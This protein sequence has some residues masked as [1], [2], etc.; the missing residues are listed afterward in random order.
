MAKGGFKVMDSD[1]HVVE[2]ADLWEHYIDPAFKDRAPQGLSRHPRD[3][4]VRVGD[5]VYPLPNRSYSNAIAPLMTAQMDVYGRVGAP[6]LGQR[7]AAERDGPRGHRRCRAVPQPRPVHPGRQQH[8]SRPGYG[9]LAGLQRLAGRLLRRGPDPVV[10]SSH[11]SAPRHRGR[12]WRGT[13]CGERTGVQDGVRA[14]QPGERP[15]LAR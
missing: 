11:D 10:W 7:V 3:L 8:R 5:S 9:H 1:M 12:Y 15:Q 6:R 14:P 4:G 13:P 2:P